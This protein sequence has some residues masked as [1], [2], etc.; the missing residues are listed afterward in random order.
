MN[1]EKYYSYEDRS[2]I[3]FPNMRGGKRAPS[4]FIVLLIIFGVIVISAGSSYVGVII[5][6]RNSA[7]KQVVVYQ[8]ADKHPVELISSGGK[9]TVAGVS[10]AVADSVVEIVTEKVYFQDSFRQYIISGAGSGVI[11][12]PDGYIVTNYHVVKN[13]N[14]ISVRLS[15]GKT[16]AAN[17]VTYD[18]RT[19]LAVIKVEVSGLIS[20]V[21]G[22]SSHL[23]PGEQVVAI[24][25]PLGSLGGTVTDGIIS[26]LGREITVE[27]D[28]LM[29]LQTN[30]AIN[31]GNSG[32]GLFNMYGDLIGIITAKSQGTGIEGIGFAIPSDTVKPV[33]QDLIE[34]GFVRGR[35]NGDI[36]KLDEVVVS[37]GMISQTQLKIAAV[38]TQKP[39]PLQSGDFIMS[40]AG[41][42]VNENRPIY[43]RTKEQWESFIKKHDA[44]DTIKI[45]Y[46]RA[47][48]EGECSFELEEKTKP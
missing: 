15:D 16:F 14:N 33:V 43:I 7:G 37:S 40:V 35:P 45:V 34:Y 36:L 28:T 29:L 6:E 31:P 19:D 8:Q 18:D 22:N 30:A 47:G 44:G 5:A 41:E 17:L 48:V 10:D 39:I 24:G 4:F 11:W 25:N 9:K 20:V 21:V 32:G 42:K 12:S 26:A 1:S 38:N 46:R 3:P 13:A 27:D 23:V 2:K